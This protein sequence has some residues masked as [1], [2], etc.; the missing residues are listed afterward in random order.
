MDDEQIILDVVVEMLEFLGHEV[1]TAHDGAEAIQVYQR[2]QAA[3]RRFDMVLLDLTVPGAMGGKEAV[4]QLLQFDPHVKAIVS[5]GY[6]SDTTVS[7]F[8][9]FGFSGVLSKP[10]TLHDIEKVIADQLR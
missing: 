1:E 6:A 5:S 7:D 3:G 9:S 4:Q 8:K 2:A 10:Y